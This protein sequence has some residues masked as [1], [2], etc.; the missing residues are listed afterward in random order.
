MRYLL[1]S[2][3]LLEIKKGDLIFPEN[4]T[5]NKFYIVESGVVKLFSRNNKDFES[6]IGPGDYFGEIGLIDESH[7]RKASAVA[8]KDCMLLTLERHDF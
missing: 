5:G 4:S 8:E 2:L 3:E 1:D 7:T 6:F